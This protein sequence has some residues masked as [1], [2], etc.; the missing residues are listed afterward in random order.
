[1]NVVAVQRLAP[2]F[3]LIRQFGQSLVFQDARRPHDWMNNRVTGFTEQDLPYLTAIDDFFKQADVPLRVETLPSHFT[4]RVGQALAQLGLVVTG[5]DAAFAGHPFAGL[6]VDAWSSVIE[7][8]HAMHDPDLEQYL[9]TRQ[10][11]FEW[12]ALAPDMLPAH[13]VRLKQPGQFHFTARING[14][15]AG[16]GTLYVQGST[17]YLALAGTLPAFRGQGVQQALLR[18]RVHQAAQLGCDLVV[19]MTG[20]GEGSGRNMQR[21]GLGL[22]QIR[23][24]W[25]RPPAPGMGQTRRCDGNKLTGNFRSN[26]CATPG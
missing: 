20:V 18:A 23:S 3:P 7:I 6:S 17:G 19:G 24:I 1:M 16:A 2:P 26:S 11:A 13:L 14:N 15:L 5:H 9:H 21:L 8:Q 25:T 22:L 12:P 4:S 10:A